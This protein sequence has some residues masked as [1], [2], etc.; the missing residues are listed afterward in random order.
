[1]NGKYH[2]LISSE[3]E[4]TLIHVPS[5]V[6]SAHL[7]LTKETATVLVLADLAWKPNDDEMKNIS[8]T[9]YNWKKWE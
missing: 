5:N 3:D 4:P 1:M 7:N 8:F 2:E 9:D 6:G